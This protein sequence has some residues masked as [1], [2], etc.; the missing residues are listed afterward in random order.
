MTTLPSAFLNQLSGVF[1]TPTK[2][3]LI[4]SL[5]TPS[6]VSIRLNP[7]F[8]GDTIHES[9]I[10]PQ[11]ERG[12]FLNERPLFTADPAFHAGLY[13]PQEANSMWIGSVFSFLRET[14]FKPDDSLLILDLCASPGGKTTDISSRMMTKDLLVANEVIPTRNSI[15][16]ENVSKWG[17]G[18]TIITKAD[19]RRFGEAGPAFDLVFC[20]A[21][22]SGEGM[23]RKDNDAISEWSL[24][25]VLLCTQRQQ[26]IL[27]D[28]WN[29]LKPGGF[30]IYS[31]CTFNRSENEDNVLAFC[32]QTGAKIIPFEH[33]KKDL[34]FELEP[35][36]YRCLPHLTPGEGLF[37]CIMQ[38]PDD[39]E[40]VSIKKTPHKKKNNKTS[41]PSMVLD[42]FQSFQKG[43]ET[44][45]LR[46]SY[47]ENTVLGLPGLVHP[48]TPLGAVYSGKWKPHPA[49]ALLKGVDFGIETI[50]LDDHAC[51]QYLKREFIPCKP[52]V[53]GPVVVLWNGHP[54][55]IANA[56]KNGLNNLLPMEWRIRGDFHAQSIVEQK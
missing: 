12:R 23:F 33:P 5:N 9:P 29:S 14:Q 46:G 25:N 50:S 20:D 39:S 51:M 38:K 18:N 3:A 10:T 56:V 34:L 45:I 16:F 47:E 13:Y 7:F 42:G 31:T 27:F 17:L 55:G 1:D 41:I 6:P 37:F 11:N 44:Y 2:D 28:V 24:D 40:A 21:P 49:I 35:N 36:Q 32:K 19:A 26:R 54:L 43:D 48:G 15:L 8:T 30:L 52:E 53:H 22:C 4:T